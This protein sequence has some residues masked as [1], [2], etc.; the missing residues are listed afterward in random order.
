MSRYGE[1]VSCLKLNSIESKDRFFLYNL[2][3][4]GYLIF[5]SFS[6]EVCEYSSQKNSSPYK[7]FENEELYYFGI[8][9]YAIKEDGTYYDVYT[10]EEIDVQKYNVLPIYK[11]ES[12]PSLYS[13]RASAFEVPYANFFKLLDGTINLFPKNKTNDCGY[14]A[15]AILLSYYANFYNCDVICQHY[16]NYTSVNNI[17]NLVE[18]W[19][20]V[21]CCTQ[22]F[23]DEVLESGLNDLGTIPID[24]ESNLQNYLNQQ[25]DMPVEGIHKA[26]V[27]TEESTKAILRRGIPLI[28]FG[29]FD[30][31]GNNS[32]TGDH[33]ILAYG[34]S[35]DGNIVAHMGWGGRSEV[36]INY[37][38]W[39]FEGGY[40]YWDFS[41]PHKHRTYTYV[42][43]QCYC[44][45]EAKFVTPE[46]NYTISQYD[47]IYHE[48][49][50]VCGKTSLFRHDFKITSSGKVK[51]QTCSDCGYWIPYIG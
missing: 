34:I 2:E 38:Y 14:V 4:G 48:N 22:S 27:V 1:V 10:H 18:N 13:S 35:S 44:V 23:K 42:R 37:K 6:N 26:Y 31:L 50:C 5:D 21:N 19:T 49:I 28:L 30:I 43:N 36:C 39:V 8:N 15:E 47:D 25:F 24:V 46:K 32:S 3:S 7:T 29:N 33:V 9:C 16:M 41:L 51:R 20:R 17:S 12:H 45:K 40:V 11:N